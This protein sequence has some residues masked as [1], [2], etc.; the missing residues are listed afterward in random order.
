AF[1]K[2]LE[3]LLQLFLVIKEFRNNNNFLSSHQFCAISNFKRFM[4]PYNAQTVL[5]KRNSNSDFR[6]TCIVL[7]LHNFILS[8]PVKLCNLCNFDLVHSN[9]ANK[10][11]ASTIEHNK[12]IHIQYLRTKKHKCTVKLF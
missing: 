5:L 8:I 12:G 7:Y 3:V 9:I 6:I 10:F 11:I 4:E 2:H 1:Y